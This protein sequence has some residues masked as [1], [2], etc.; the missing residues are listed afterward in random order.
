MLPPSSSSFGNPYAYENKIRGD[1]LLARGNTEEAVEALSMAAAADPS[2]P[3]LQ[4][5]FAEA[6]MQKND[7][8]RA[9]NH[10]AKA[11]LYGA[12]N[13]RTW[14]AAARLHHRLG[15]NE[16]AVAA[17]TFGAQVDRRDTSAL[18]W[19]GDYFA[20]SSDA[21]QQQTALL[22]YQ[23]ALV[24]NR[25]DPELYLA[26]GKISL[27]LQ[28]FD[29]AKRYME[30]YLDLHG[31]EYAPVM[32]AALQIARSGQSQ[33]AIDMLKTLLIRNP[34]GDEVRRH[35]VELYLDTHQYPKVV[36]TVLSFFAEPDTPEVLQQ[37]INWLLQANAPW[38]AR[39]L[40]VEHFST[41][42]THPLVRYQLARIESVLLRDEMALAL[43]RF[44][45][46]VPDSIAQM[47]EKLKEEIDAR[48]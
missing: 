16:Q 1:I 19:L 41:L 36:D 26:A 38:E 48:H 15:E 32:R 3:W 27:K 46:D 8:E 25:T 2:N 34:L 18:R 13:G 42:P 37:R 29:L 40:L 30:R 20:G 23:R 14:T 47:A 17:A 39:D 28:H 6:L 35:L 21:A 7:L 33:S 9:R 43:L 5:Q 24:R 11:L 45:G 44:E 12:A 4:T 22:H 31:Q 10:L